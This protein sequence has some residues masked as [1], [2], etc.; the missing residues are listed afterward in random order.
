M[1]IA[2]FTPFSRKSAIGRFSRAV[3]E[4]LKQL[5]FV[6]IWHPET[7]D[8]LQS[9]CPTRSFRKAEDVR[10]EVLS[11]YDCVVYNL[12][13]YVPFHLEIYRLSKAFPGFLI[14]HDF[15]MHHFFA[16]YLLEQ[17]RDENAYLELIERHYGLAGLAAASA[18]LEGKRPPLWETDEVLRY[19]L[20]EEAVIGARGVI[21][22]SSFFLEPARRACA[23]PVERLHLAYPAA[24]AAVTRTEGDLSL[25]EGRVVAVSVGHVN[26]NKRILSVLRAIAADEHLRSRM[27]YVIAGPEDPTYGRE[28]RQ[29]AEENGLAAALQFRGYVDDATLH[30]LLARADF[31]INLRYPPTESGSASL[32]EQLRAGKA[33]VVSNA[34]CYVDLPDSCAMKVPVENEDSEL[35]PVLRRLVEDSRLR[36]QIGMRGKEFAEEHFSPGRYA[37]DFSRAVWRMGQDAPVLSLTDTVSTELLRMGVSA[38]D[39]LI[40]HLAR[41]MEQLFCRGPV[42]DSPSDEPL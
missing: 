21:V 26:R 40:D 11:S 13:N 2:W 12:G 39:P 5:H 38:G 16:S 9:D 14:L 42:A 27:Y 31:C 6:D 7:G 37:R 1:K 23:C 10:H 15:V 30:S 36:E 41:E 25:P 35:G 18:Y 20:F 3:A 28:I 19:P 32:I 8:V 24:Q 22:H 33:V 17:Q 34:G 4:E 29:F